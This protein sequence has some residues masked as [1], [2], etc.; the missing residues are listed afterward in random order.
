MFGNFNLWIL[1]KK[2]RLAYVNILIDG[3]INV[4]APT[5]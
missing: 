4:R 1:D 2:S 5:Y 3:S